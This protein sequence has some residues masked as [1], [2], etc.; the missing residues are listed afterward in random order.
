MSRLVRFALKIKLLP[1]RIDEDKIIFT[2]LS[3]TSLISLCVHFIFSFS[4]GFVL[5]TSGPYTEYLQYLR[6][7]QWNIYLVSMVAPF[8]LMQILLFS[9]PIVLSSGLPMVPNLILDKQLRI[10]RNGWTMLL[11]FGILTTSFGIGKT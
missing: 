6:L 8:V 2:F 4:A 5:V 10:P 1:L 3:S 11:S 7:T 9:F